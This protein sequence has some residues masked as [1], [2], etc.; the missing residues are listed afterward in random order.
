MA[1]CDIQLRAPFRNR[2]AYLPGSLLVLEA[3]VGLTFVFSVYSTA[4]AL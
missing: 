2:F 3:N 1:L 4:E